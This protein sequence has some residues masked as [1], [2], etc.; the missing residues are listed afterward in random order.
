MCCALHI[1]VCVCVLEKGRAEPTRPS[2][3]APDVCQEGKDASAPTPSAV[4]N[5]LSS[6]DPSQ[7]EAKTPRRTACPARTSKLR[8]QPLPPLPESEAPGEQTVATQPGQEQE[9]GIFGV[10]EHAAW[11]PGSPAHPKCCYVWRTPRGADDGQ[12]GVTKLSVNIL[13]SIF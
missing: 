11:S 10:A 13:F 7:A 9:R 1:R 6:A 12:R 5:R 8:L 3:C 4:S 2:C